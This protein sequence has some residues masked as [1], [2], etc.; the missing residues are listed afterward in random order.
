MAARGKKD[1]DSERE[2]ERDEPEPEAAPTEKRPRRAHVE[3]TEPTDPTEE[4]GPLTALTEGL[5]EIVPGLRVLDRELV[6]EGG[7]RADLAAV[8]PSG[9]LHLVLLAH[10]D[11][12]K[13][14]LEALDAVA[15]VRT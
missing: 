14:A 15:V 2:P 12:D 11:A 3:P 1:D 9:R 6:F 4:R 13:A 8:D 5:D 10:E 7:G